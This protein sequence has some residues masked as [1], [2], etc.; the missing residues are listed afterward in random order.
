MTMPGREDNVGGYRYG[1]NGMEFDTEVKGNQN[2]Y[3]TEFRQYDPRLGRWLSLDPL[4]AKYPSMSPYLAFNNNPIYFTDPLGLEGEPKDGDVKTHNNSKYVYSSKSGWAREVEEVNFAI[5]IYKSS[6]E[7]KITNEK[8]PF[9]GTIAIP[10][11]SY[12]KYNN[13]GELIQ[14]V[15]SQKTY[16]YTENNDGTFNGYRSNDG[17]LYDGKKEVFEE[18]SWYYNEHKS[19][20]SGKGLS[21]L[22]H[23]YT[24]SKPKYKEGEWNEA[25]AE[26][27][28]LQEII[29]NG[30]EKLVKL[31]PNVGSND[32]LIKA[33]SEGTGDQFELKKRRVGKVINQNL[34][35]GYWADN[36]FNDKSYFVP[37]GTKHAGEIAV[38]VQKVQYMLLY[39][40]APIGILYEDK[41]DGIST[42]EIIPVPG[43]QNRH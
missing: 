22:D 26:T 6:P 43:S 13:K 23:V 25:E 39:N 24:S 20:K 11:N 30:I 38:G 41:L 27:F 19:T 8:T 37:I 18:L 31:Y 34:W 4:M 15:S 3:T 36:I 17:S 16:N 1:Y 12:Q 21:G 29:A 7:N 10:T 14:F 9:G 32:I 42:P 33:L 28:L 35:F 2:S 40:G 5:T